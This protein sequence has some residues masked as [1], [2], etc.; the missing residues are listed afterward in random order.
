MLINA[1][2][3]E[4]THHLK[5]GRVRHFRPEGKI[6]A[7]TDT[8]RRVAASEYRKKRNP[9]DRI[10][11]GGYAARIFVGLNVGKETKWTI[12]DVIRI[13]VKTRKAQK[14]VPDASIIAQSGIY[15]DKTG[16]L[17]VEPS[18][19]IVI[20]DLAGTP[21]AAFLKEMKRLA[22]LLRKQLQQETVI[23]EIQKSGV[24]EDVY[25]VT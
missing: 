9:I 10:G 17:V 6:Y 22:E 11:D 18:V 3:G 13:V 23:L 4:V 24:S 15:Q 2:L 20:I 21:K 7:V 25:S 1:H 19:Q 8:G 16:D 12:D 5:S 14:R